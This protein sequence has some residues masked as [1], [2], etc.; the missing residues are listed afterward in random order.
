MNVASKRAGAPSSRAFCVAA[1]RSA[2]ASC[3]RSISTPPGYR[4]RATSPT[5]RPWSKRSWSTLSGWS[6]VA[7]GSCTS[8]QSF[9]WHWRPEVKRDFERRRGEGGMIKGSKEADPSL[10]RVRALAQ[11]DSSARR[12]KK[13]KGGEVISFL[14]YAKRSEPVIPSLRSGR[15]LSAAGAKDLLFQV[16]ASIG[17][18]R[19][20]F[21]MLAR[22][23]R[24][25]L[26]LRQ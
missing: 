11:D 21:E 26:S 6:S 4:A 3:G 15:A 19:D 16:L 12:V 25:G 5:W 13:G 10:S 20:K 9:L 2:R 7:F 24:S 17:T 14:C 1:T 8:H 18:G 23:P 22:R